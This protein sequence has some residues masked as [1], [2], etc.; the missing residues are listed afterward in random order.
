MPIH[1][2]SGH[3]SK[4]KLPKAKEGA[5]L[6]TDALPNLLEMPIQDLR[7]LLVDGA[8]G[9]MPAHPP[10]QASVMAKQVDIDMIDLS[11]NNCQDYMYKNATTT[12]KSKQAP[13]ALLSNHQIPTRELK[14]H[15]TPAQSLVHCWRITAACCH[16]CS[17]K[18]GS[19]SR[20]SA[21]PHTASSGFLSLHN[22]F[23]EASENLM[24]IYGD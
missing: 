6:S 23:S 4:M 15:S 18:A 24:V 14:Y 9:K 2:W 21:S 1:T 22:A 16:I 13:E 10:V 12:R 3:S 17:S 20:A 11:E 5:P 7:N 19:E 8:V